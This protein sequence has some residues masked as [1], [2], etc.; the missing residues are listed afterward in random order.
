VVLEYYKVTITILT[1][2]L[3]N[4]F[5]NKNVKVFLF[6]IRIRLYRCSYV[7]SI[8]KKPSLKGILN[9]YWFSR[10]GS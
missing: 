7:I 1:L 6:Y 5:F 10:K 3:N 8:L 2:K 9:L 4:S